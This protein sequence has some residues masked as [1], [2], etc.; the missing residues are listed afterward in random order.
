[1]LHLIWAKDNTSVNSED[2]KELKGVRSRLLECYRALYFEPVPDLDSKGNILRVAKNMIEYVVTS[3][4]DSYAH[5]RR[6]QTFDAT[7]ADLTSLEE[8]MRIMMLE[9]R[10]QPGV[11]AK[12]W[13]I[14]SKL[15][16]QP[17]TDFA[18]LS[19]QV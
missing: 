10:I 15:Y 1:M 5:F 2:G 18:H 8:M 3:Y 11:I 4:L 13:E 14:Y 19:G 9:D 12:L 16:I 6:R 17:V 7:L